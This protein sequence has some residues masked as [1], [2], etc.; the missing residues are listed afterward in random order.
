MK[1][2]SYS[3]PKRLGKK[4]GARGATINRSMKSARGKLKV[5][6]NVLNFLSWWISLEAS[7]ALTNRVAAHNTPS[8]QT[9]KMEGGEKSSSSAPIATYIY[10]YSNH[11]TVKR[12]RNIWF[13]L[14]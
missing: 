5:T 10:P 11:T 7:V 12:L 3:L 1:G 4:R 9:S 2:R 13:W 8:T 6:L 14:S